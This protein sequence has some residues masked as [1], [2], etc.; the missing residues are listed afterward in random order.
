MYTSMNV[1]TPTSMEDDATDDHLNVSV[2]IDQTLPISS[3]PR[4]FT[5][6]L[7]TNMSSLFTTA[8]LELGR[9]DEEILRLRQLLERERRSLALV[10]EAVWLV[11][12]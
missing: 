2:E 8:R 5:H 3:S 4:D 9:K 1:T 7:E 10:Q 12:Y 11:M 6:I